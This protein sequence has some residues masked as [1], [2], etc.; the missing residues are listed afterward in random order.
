MKVIKLLAKL[1]PCPVPLRRVGE[2]SAEGMYCGSPIGACVEVANLEAIRART[3]IGDLRRCYVVDID[4][5][6]GRLLVITWD[7]GK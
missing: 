4:V 7:W 5:M 1:K 2:T 3:A 6:D